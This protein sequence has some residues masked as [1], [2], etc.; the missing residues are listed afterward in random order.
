MQR[1]FRGMV[2]YAGLFPPA[3]CTMARAVE[4]YAGY[5]DGPDQLLLGRFVVA[6]S[7]L[8]ELGLEL[9]AWSLDHPLGSRWP[10]AVVFGNNLP[11][12]LSRIAQFNAS[13]HGAV[14]TIEAVEFKVSSIGQIA[15][16]AGLLPTGPARFMEV[17][18][19][20]PYSELITAIA[21][22]G[23]FAK[24][25][26]GGVTPEVFPSPE[27]L[28]RFLMAVTRRRL[29][30]K[31]T[32]GLHHPF[33]GSYPLT[34][35]PEAESHVMFG[36]VNLFLATASLMHGAEGETAQAILEEDDL[37]AFR[38]D[39]TGWSWR[40]LRWSTEELD[41]V[42][43]YGFTSFGSCSFEDPVRELALGPSA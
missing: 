15:Y 22:A 7:R 27:E 2:D 32:A 11:I 38:G 12:E 20:G 18:S 19:E 14:T 28:T 34:Y 23:A 10:L 21:E 8:D 17:P 13:V 25:R 43:Q 33:R 16:L 30:F 24:V 3:S 40:E 4:Q 5:R 42:R 37:T 9:A 26:T 41:E 39:D 6:A 35:Q 29:P 31:A 36:F 1:V